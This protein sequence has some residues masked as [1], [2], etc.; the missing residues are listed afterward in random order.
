MSPSAT[1]WLVRE[2]FN[3]FCTTMEVYRTETILVGSINFDFG[4]FMGFFVKNT[5]LEQSL[6]FGHV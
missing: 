2:V 5:F 3:S 4:L 1:V 6:F